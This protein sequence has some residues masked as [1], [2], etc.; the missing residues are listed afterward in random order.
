MNDLEFSGKNGLVRHFIPFFDFLNICL[1]FCSLKPDLVCVDTE[2]FA[3]NNQSTIAAIRQQVP[4]G[5]FVKISTDDCAKKSI[6]CQYE[7]FNLRPQ[8]MLSLPVRQRRCNQPGPAGL[9]FAIFAPG[10]ENRSSAF[11]GRL[12]PQ[13]L[14]SEEGSRWG[15]ASSVR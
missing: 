2:D 15:P 10:R 12:F 11:P 5:A 9:H 14:I 13:P 4:P 8:Q 7:Q 6:C 1:F 3:I